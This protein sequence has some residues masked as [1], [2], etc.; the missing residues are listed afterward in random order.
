M[1]T[2]SP[3][4]QTNGERRA[5]NKPLHWCIVHHRE[6]TELRANG[7]RWCGP[8]GIMVPCIVFTCVDVSKE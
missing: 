4:T 1:Q 6:A 5:T 8:G 3:M 7:N 2:N